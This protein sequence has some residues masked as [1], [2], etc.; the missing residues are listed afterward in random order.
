MARLV[1]ERAIVVQALLGHIILVDPRVL[2]AGGVLMRMAGV[3][4]SDL[5]ADQSLNTQAVIPF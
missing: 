2:I 3:A 4:G 1:P 5:V